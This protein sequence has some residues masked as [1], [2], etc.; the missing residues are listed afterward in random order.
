M[1][2]LGLLAWLGLAACGSSG[3]SGGG[4][5]GGDHGYSPKACLVDPECP[6][7]LL[8]A[9]R[10][11]CGDE[12]ENTIAAVLA[13]QRAGVPMV[14]VDTRETADG[15]V[16]IMHDA[17]VERTTDGERR[18]DGR[19]AVDELSLAEFETLRIDDPRCG[20]DDEDDPDRCHPPTLQ[21]L[22]AATDDGLLLDID[23]KAGDPARLARVV[24]EADAVD[25]VLVF[26]SDFD[27]LRA[28]HRELPQVQVMPRGHQPADFE[29][30]LQAADEAG[31]GLRW[32]HGDARD[33]ETVAELLAASGVRLYI[34]AWDGDH[35]ADIWAGA[36]ELLEDPEERQA[37]W[38][39]AYEALDT[40]CAAGARALGTD[41]GHRYVEHLY[42]DGFGR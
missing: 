37:M 14:E 21:Q 1:S 41:F 33:A 17:D 3:G 39:R 35:P 10:G 23:F 7:V 13:C 6:S 31:I 24:R 8:S 36:A 34:N 12:P 16:V 22:L 42:P 38:Q 5:D 18:F 20:G 2:L 40:M 30:L 11:L 4:T 28:V 26:D 29:A 32:A 25:R 9:H 27:T 19:S 15:R